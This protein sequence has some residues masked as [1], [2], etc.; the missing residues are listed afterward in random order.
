[1]AIAA[2]GLIAGALDLTQ[3][4]ILFG[5]HIPLLIAGGLLGLRAVHGGIATYVLGVLLHFFIALSFAAVY[6]AAS[7]RLVFLTEH[8]LVCGLFYGAAV[9]VVMGYIVL[10]LSAL[11]ARG[12]YELHDVIQGLLVHMVV[13]GLPISFSVRRFANRSAAAPAV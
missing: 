7:R 6:Y 4:C 12:P 3:A 11:H 1:L 9:E 13:V 5:W 10:P 2:G 8:P